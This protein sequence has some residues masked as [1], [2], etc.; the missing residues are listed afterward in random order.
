M[1]TADYAAD[2]DATEKVYRSWVA[3]F[4]TGEATM[5]Q[6]DQYVSEWN[7]AGGQ[8]MTDYARTVLK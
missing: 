1:W 4:I 7:A 8:H 6:W 2:T 3:K 5:D